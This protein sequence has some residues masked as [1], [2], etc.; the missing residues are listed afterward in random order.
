MTSTCKNTCLI[1]LILICLAVLLAHIFFF[2]YVYPYIIADDA[3][4]SLRY[5]QRFL[6]GKGLTWN[7]GEYVEGYSNLL[8]VLFNAALG[9][10]GMALPKATQMLGVIATLLTPVVFWMHARTA[11]LM[12][13]PLLIG[14]FAF[15]VATPVAIWAVAGMET[16]LVM[17]LFAAAL[18][19]CYPLLD[20]PLAAN[21]CQSGVALA[22]V[23]P[24]RPEG[25]I[26]TIATALG[27]MLFSTLP[28]RQRLRMTAILCVIPMICFLLQ[29]AFRVSYYHQWFP[30][31][32]MVKVAFTPERLESGFVYIVNALYFFLPLLIY[33]VIN[34]WMARKNP[35]EARTIRYGGFLFTILAFLSVAILINGGDFFPCFRAFLPVFPVIIL[36]LMHGVR[37]GLT[38]APVKK[39]WIFLGYVLACHVW[40]Q[41]Q[42]DTVQAPE[43]RDWIINAKA[44]G[45]ALKEKYG[46]MHPQPTIAVF[47]AGVIPYYSELPALDVF[48][49]TD[50]YLATHR[51]TITRFG[52]GVIGHE[53]FD[54]Q[55][56]ASQKPDILVFDI[57]GSY[58]CKAY[59][60]ECAVILPHYRPDALHIPGYDV[61]I[62]VRKDSKL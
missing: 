2:Y 4:I 57:P 52:K 61:K 9:Y 26:Y 60:D 22:L 5:A 56:I 62:W 36:L 43:A 51:N 15:A 19:S 33:A 48:G 41:W 32:V 55:Y 50:P 46:A 40:Q 13:W 6:Q 44:M 49:L 17:L 8:W 37:L 38:Y 16:P 27:L 47:A 45:L 53:L 35:A 42:V 14:F 21:A 54:G 1:S 58:L 7:D 23:C 31:T 3:F 18:I 20:T 28:F 25:P 29:L 12:G 39:E 59:P 11:K 34:Y 24:L 30:N 10:L